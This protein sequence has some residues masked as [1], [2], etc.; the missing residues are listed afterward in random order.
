MARK[1]KLE[2]KVRL[3]LKEHYSMDKNQKE[4]DKIYQWACQNKSATAHK[5]CFTPIEESRDSYF[6]KKD[7]Q[8]YLQEYSHDNLP[9][10]REKLEELWTAD[11]EMEQV[12]LPVLV[13]IM[14]NNHK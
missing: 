13:G 11:E 5:Q 2:R 8:S 6:V 9:D 10:F 1:R 12:L 14:K 7:N 4:K 3:R